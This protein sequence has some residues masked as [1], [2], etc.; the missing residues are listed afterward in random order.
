MYT[1]IIKVPTKRVGV[2]N[3]IKQMLKTAYQSSNSTKR[4]SIKEITASK[5]GSMAETGITFEVEE[6]VT[7]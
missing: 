6:N 7:K 1:I 5:A 3:K 4:H 2:N